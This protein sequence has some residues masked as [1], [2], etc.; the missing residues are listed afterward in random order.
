MATLALHN[1]D[2]EAVEK[3]RDMGN[4]GLQMLL[5]EYQKLP[6]ATQKQQQMF[7]VIDRV[8]G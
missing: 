4:E 1:N 6:L 7:D 3:L 2:N 5:Q 8:A